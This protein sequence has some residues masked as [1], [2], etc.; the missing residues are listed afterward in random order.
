MKKCFIITV[1]LLG[2]FFL[3]KD[4]FAQTTITMCNSG[5]D[6]KSFDEVED[7][8]F[9]NI[10]TDSD[11]IIELGEG[12]YLGELNLNIIEKL[13]IV[14]KSSESTVL[15]PSFNRVDDLGIGKYETY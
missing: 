9:N 8:Y 10:L 13:K 14:G 7:A 12:E 4:V 1:V 5:C 11:L 3:P 2:I 6:Y 15:I